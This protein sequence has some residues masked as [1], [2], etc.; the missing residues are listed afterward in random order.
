M[1]R[2][3]VWV[4]RV[5]SK[6]QNQNIETLRAHGARKIV[7]HCPHCLNT[8]KNEY[9]ENGQPEFTVV[10]HSQL[11][12][13]AGGGGKDKVGPGTQDQG[14][15]FHDPCYLGRHNGEYDA[16]RAVVG[17]V[18]GTT[19]VEMDRSREKSFCCGGWRRPD[20]AGK[21]GRER[22]EGMRLAE[23]ED[24]GARYDR[25]RVPLLQDH[26]GKCFGNGRKAGA[27]TDKRY[28]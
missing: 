1:I 2:P 20:V 13:H 16:P 18:P 25:Y 6:L 27:G 3:A 24:T 26:A 12:Q 4:T 14:I 5:V 7:T 15:T 22:V 10:H 11:L 23:A 17:S 21:R 9:S 8:L 19:L 28:C